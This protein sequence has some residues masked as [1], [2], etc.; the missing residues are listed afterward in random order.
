MS[1]LGEAIAEFD[2]FGSRCAALV[3]GSGSAGG[4]RDGARLARVRLLEWHERFSRFL[5]DSELSLLNGDPRET[6]PV[7]P[8]MARLAEAIVLAGRISGG[9]VDSTLLGQIRAAGYEHDHDAPLGLARMLELAPPRAAAAP[10]AAA[11]WSMI[12]VDRDAG[13]VTRPPG[14]LLDSGGIAKGMFADVLAEEL[15]DH[16]GLA[17]NCAGDLRIGGSAA[18]SRLVNVESPF[19][20]SILHS[21]EL[22]D[23]GVATSGI[24]RR[25][26]IDDRGRPAHHLLDPSTGRPA[27]TG[28][29]QA[30][31]VAPSAL[32]AEV[33]AKAALLSGPRR[34]AAWMQ[35]GGVIV[36][37][38]GSHVVFKPPAKVTLGELSALLPA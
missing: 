30:T 16:V 29:V 27:F 23:A 8:L 5:P 2:C 37:D 28:I 7:S 14:L 34:A 20:G 3:S 36:L 31:A 1:E 38:N 17:F 19:D 24:G 15:A 13:T 35:D 33:R 10:A 6:V 9:L 26:W 32:I 4:A 12:S 18:P 21:F 22:T 11:A 25:S